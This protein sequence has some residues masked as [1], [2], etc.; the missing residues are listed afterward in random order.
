MR[1]VPRKKNEMQKLIDAV[2]ISIVIIIVA[3]T[4]TSCCSQKPCETKKQDINKYHSRLKNK[5]KY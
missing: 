3:L 5:L 4:L 2:Y 1:I